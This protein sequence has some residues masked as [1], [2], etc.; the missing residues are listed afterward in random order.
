MKDQFEKFETGMNTLGAFVAK[1]SEA[2]KLPDNMA[3]IS[4]SGDFTQ[5]TIFANWAPNE[6]GRQRILSVVGE[7]FGRDG[8]TRK[9]EVYNGTFNWL[10]TLD[11]VHVTVQ[12]A[13]KMPEAEESP[14]YPNEFPIM[15]NDRAGND[16]LDND[17]DII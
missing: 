7:A 9:P 13:Q 11:G 17:N 3:Q 12:S 5:C 15:L 6:D 4:L 16:I 2:L 8:W 14:V 10:K 1:Y